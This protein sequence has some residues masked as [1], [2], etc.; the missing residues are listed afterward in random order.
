MVC[1]F[2]PACEL[3]P[4]WTKEQYLCTVAP[5]SSLWPPPLP[6][7]NVQYIKTVCVTGGGGGDVELCCRPYSA[8]VL[9]SV[10]GQIQ[11]LQNC[12]TTPK[13]MTSKDDIKGLLSLSSFLHA[14]RPRVTLWCGAGRPV[15]WFARIPE[16][17][18]M[19]RLFWHHV[20]GTG[21]PTSPL[22]W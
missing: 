8:V 20:A 9:H 14:T 1:I 18:R 6:K 21:R 11:N 15:S 10:S 7:L 2:D 4:P 16:P 3:L 12:Y 22:V 17:I 13:Q 19:R 5:L